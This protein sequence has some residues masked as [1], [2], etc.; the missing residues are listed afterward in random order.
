MLL[1]KYA[2]PDY[3]TKLGKWFIDF[4]TK[5]FADFDLPIIKEI[6]KWSP[7]KMQLVTQVMRSNPLNTG[8]K[9]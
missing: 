7:T 9:F 5:R 8:I 6:L 2:I 3:E 1:E 4:E